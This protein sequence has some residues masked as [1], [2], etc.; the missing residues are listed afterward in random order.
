M[1]PNDAKPAQHTETTYPYNVNL[2]L[3]FLKVAFSHP[4]YSIFTPQSYHHPEPIF[5]SCST[6]MTSPSHTSTSAVK[7]YIPTYSFVWTKHNNLTINPDK[8]TCTL[9]TP[10]PAEY[11]SNLDLKVTSLHY[12]WQRTQWLWVLP[13]H[14]T[15]IQHTHS[16]LLSTRTRTSTN[17]KSTHRKRMG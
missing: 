1:T 9:F 12:P 4:H 13:R 10:D 15:R 16:Q 17:N 8:T 2:K 14:K 6:Q 5:S 3:S 11:K 7:K